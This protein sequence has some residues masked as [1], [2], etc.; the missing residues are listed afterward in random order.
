MTNYEYL[1]GM[2]RKCQKESLRRTD[3]SLKSFY[4]NAEIGFM[5]KAQTLPVEK[6]KAEH[7]VVTAGERE[8]LLRGL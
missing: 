8:A 7:C 1:M 2:S 4:K 3:V 6:A 5:V